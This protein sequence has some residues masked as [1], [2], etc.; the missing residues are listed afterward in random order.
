MPESEEP[1][2]WFERDDGDVRLA[3][4][5]KLLAG[6]YPDLQFALNFKLTKV[7]LR[8]SITLTEEISGVPSIIKVRIV[9][10]DKYPQIEPVAFDDGEHFPHI[11]DRHFYTI[12]MCCLW[13]PVE[14]LWKTDETDS[15]LDFVDQVSIFFERQLVYDAGGGWIWGE[16]GHDEKGYIEFFEEQLGNDHDSIKAFLPLL[17]EQTALSKKSKCPCGSN[18]AYAYCHKSKV[19]EIKE[20]IR[21]SRDAGISRLAEE[22]V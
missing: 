3:H 12:G 14:S 5:R 15:L 18:R 19:E 7:I 20:A 13:L 2:K 8:G 22:Y 16:R 6:K 9:L 1:L 17:V 10:P 11:P 21:I 4:D